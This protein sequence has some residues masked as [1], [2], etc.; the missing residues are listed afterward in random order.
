MTEKSGFAWFGR[1]A[2]SKDRTDASIDT[3]EPRRDSAPVPASLR[4]CPQAHS[5]ALLRHLQ[6]TMQT[7]SVPACR[8]MD[9]YSVM[10]ATA[11]LDKLP[12]LSV[13]R[14]FRP[15]C[16]AKAPRT[17]I[18]DGR[19]LRLV[20]YEVP[21]AGSAIP[22][23]APARSLVARVARLERQLEQLAAAQRAA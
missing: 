2:S 4:W 8:V 10:C 15:L 1:A 12:W 13:A 21:S 23:E 20:C 22:T 18:S 14:R 11:G 5:E 17:I 9:A 6:R 7:G 3:V 16:L 19:P